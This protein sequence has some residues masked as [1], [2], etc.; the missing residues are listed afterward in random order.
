M[1]KPNCVK[2]IEALDPN[3]NV[4]TDKELEIMEMWIKLKMLDKLTREK[5]E[6]NMSIEK[7]VEKELATIIAKSDTLKKVNELL[8]STETKDH[9]LM[10]EI[11]RKAEESLEEIRLVGE[12]DSRIKGYIENYLK[13]ILLATGEYFN[14]EGK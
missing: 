7:E 13:S 8:G 2:K 5:E 6:T 9:V 12:V 10:Q 1:K 11:Q 4:L 14:M 3:R